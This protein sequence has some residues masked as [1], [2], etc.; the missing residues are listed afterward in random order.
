MRIPVIALTL[1][2]ALVAAT[3][4]VAETIEGYIP[5][6]DSVRIHFLQAGAADARHTLL[7]IPGWQIS[8]SIWSTQLDHFSAHGYRVIAMDPRSQGGSTVVQSGNAPEDRARDVHAVIEGSNSSTS[9]SWAGPRASRTW[10]PTWTTTA[11]P[12]WTRWRW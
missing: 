9:R 10:P 12:L 1:T 6:A 3:P 8:A 5:G 7:L 2:S 11:P 4:A